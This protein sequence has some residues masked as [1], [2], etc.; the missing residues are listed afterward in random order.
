MKCIKCTECYIP[1]SC[2]LVNVCYSTVIMFN[3]NKTK[4]IIQIPGPCRK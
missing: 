2:A 3:K 1:E 4:F